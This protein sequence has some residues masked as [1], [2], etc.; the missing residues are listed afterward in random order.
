[1]REALVL[2]Q[3]S[4][5]TSAYRAIAIGSAEVGQAHAGASLALNPA[6][7]TTLVSSTAALITH[8]LIYMAVP[9]VVT[10]PEPTDPPPSRNEAHHT[11]PPARSPNSIHTALRVQATNGTCTACN[12]HQVIIQKECQPAKAYYANG[13]TAPK[14]SHMVRTCPFSS[15]CNASQ[16]Q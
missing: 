15:P 11:A 13:E 1:M 12:K 16:P 4:C 6:R 7:V 5:G 10:R 2:L 14:L 8:I 9:C 3:C